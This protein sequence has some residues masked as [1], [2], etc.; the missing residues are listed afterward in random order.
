MKP[1]DPVRYAKSGKE[2]AKVGGGKLSSA[3]WLPKIYR[4]KY[5]NP[6]GSTGQVDF[7]WVR[8]AHGGRRHAVSLGT[9]DKRVAAGKAARM[10]GEVIG[11]GWDAALASIDPERHTARTGTR[12]GDV[13]TTLERVDL[14]DRTRANYVNCLRW[15]AARHLELKPGPKEYSRQ[16]EE[17]R[18]KLAAVP[19]VELSQTRIEAIRDAFIAQADGDVARERRARISAKSYLRNARAGIAAAR[20][21]GRMEL[22]E[23]IPFSGVTV[24]GAVT[25]PYRSRI[26]ATAILRAARSELRVEDPD[27]YR[28]I[29]L[30]LGAGLRPGEITSLMW[31]NVDFTAGKVWIEIG[32]QWEAK[33]TE[34][35]AAVDVDEGLLR[36]LLPYQAGPDDRVVAADAGEHAVRWLR[37]QGMDASINKP[38]HTLRKEFGSIV[39]AG[40][41]LLTA[42]R[43]LRHS[44]LAVTAAFYVEARKKAAPRIGAMLDG[45]DNEVS[46]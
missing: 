20:K 3:Y 7:W 1:S 34:S 14:R 23:P 30:A 38:L 39:T 35:E 15:W 40:A 43:Q 28:V 4:P 17:W 41:D 13:L 29:L 27:A 37:K 46:R 8:V 2:V 9:A 45:G 12:L 26:D 10:Y 33:T 31:R 42:S 25:L 24:N 6:D 18:A 21:L 19:L 44:S 32:G 5:T 11:K 16:S 22:S 36:E